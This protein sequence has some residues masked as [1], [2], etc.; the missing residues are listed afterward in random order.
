MKKKQGFKSNNNN[1]NN[2]YTPRI[3]R[4]ENCVSV[5]VWVNK[6]IVYTQAG[7]AKAVGCEKYLRETFEEFKN[8]VVQNIRMKEKGADVRIKATF[9]KERI[10]KNKKEWDI[11]EI[12]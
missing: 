2:K 4:H 9:K 1:S 11:I 12:A 8:F 10:K 6:K 3:E 7:A 5:S